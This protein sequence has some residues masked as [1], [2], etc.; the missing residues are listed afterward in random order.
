MRVG[1]EVE[2]VVGGAR[3]HAPVRLVGIDAER[4]AHLRHSV[5]PGASV[6]RVPT[7]RHRAAPARCDVVRA[8][9]GMPRPRTGTT[10]R[11]AGSESGVA[12]K[13]GS[14]KVSTN[15]GFALL[16]RRTSVA[17]RAL[18]PAARLAFPSSTASAPTTAAAES[19][20]PPADHSFGFS[21]RFSACA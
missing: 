14:T 6:V 17:P 11:F 21:A 19:S 2:R 3:L 7:E 16:S 1:R 5:R 9:R 10:S 4:E 15:A 20:T 12:W 13:S 8:G 18:M